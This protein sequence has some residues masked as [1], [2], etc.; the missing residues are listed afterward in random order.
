LGN[1]LLGTGP[2]EGGHEVAETG[3]GWVW[4]PDVGL[5]VVGFGADFVGFLGRDVRRSSYCCAYNISCFERCLEERI[6]FNP[7][8]RLLPTLPHKVYFIYKKNLRT[9]L[10]IP[11]T[12]QTLPH[13]QITAN[14]LTHFFQPRPTITSMHCWAI[15]MWCFHLLLSRQV[16]QLFGP[17]EGFGEEGGGDAMVYD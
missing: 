14:N 8:P 6:I 10:T 1:N 5:F 11:H 17:G 13:L 4:E 16:K 9:Y 3:E 7:I 15:W 12:P 2:V